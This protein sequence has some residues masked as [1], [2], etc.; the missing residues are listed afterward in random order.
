[1]KEFCGENQ[2]RICDLIL[3]LDTFTYL[4]R[5]HNSTSWLDHVLCSGDVTVTDIKV[6]NNLS[7][8]DHFPITVKIDLKTGETLTPENKNLVRQFIDW[9][10]FDENVYNSKV[11]ELLCGISICD[12]VRCISDHRKQIDDCYEQL[13]KFI[14]EASQDF[15]YDRET[16]FTPV[17]GWNKYCK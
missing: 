14:S 12:N 11:E 1:M 16:K 3:P 6:L 4:S 7:F 17:P 15:L 13:V 5:S 8:F 2:F 9:T 10:K